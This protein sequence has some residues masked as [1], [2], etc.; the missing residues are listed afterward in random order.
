MNLQTLEAAENWLA[1]PAETS[2]VQEFND[3]CLWLSP[4][5]YMNQHVWEIEGIEIGLEALASCFPEQ[6]ERVL[7]AIR[8]RYLTWDEAI[9][10]VCEPFRAVTH[11]DIW[12]P[13]QLIGGVP[14]FAVG[15]GHEAYHGNDELRNQV[16]PYL[17]AAGIDAVYDATSRQDDVIR[18]LV[19]SLSR[20]PEPFWQQ[21]ANVLRWVFLH[22]FENDLLNWD[23]YEFQEVWYGSYRDNLPWTP[24]NIEYGGCLQRDALSMW[25]VIE[26]WLQ[27]HASNRWIIRQFQMN[28]NRGFHDRR[29]RKFNWTRS[30]QRSG[31]PLTAGTDYVL[32][33]LNT[34]SSLARH[35][36]NRRASRL[37]GGTIR[38]AGRRSNAG[39]GS[40]AREHTA[41]R[42]IRRYK[43]HPRVCPAQTRRTLAGWRSRRAARPVAG[44]RHAPEMER[45]GLA[46][47]Q[48]L[49]GD[50][51]TDD[52]TDNALQSVVA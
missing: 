17:E 40:A 11:F 34:P 50:R 42:A 10:L 36:R 33:P 45:S 51:A 27:T 14:L 47:I 3:A 25:G 1:N 44:V 6:H 18:R 5:H 24:E 4:A 26:T 32:Q 30:P 48:H 35:W 22:N 52:V 15:F 46:E 41:R 12:E 23:H 2:V 38:R 37:T 43:D 13:V 49:D 20:Q 9:D 8:T 21:M 7:Q 28:Y 29:I 31:R 19:K 16:I 39:Y